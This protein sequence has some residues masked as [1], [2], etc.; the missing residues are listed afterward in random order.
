[1]LIRVS[2]RRV[3]DIL[4]WTKDSGVFRHAVLVLGAHVWDAHVHYFLIKN[5]H[6]HAMVWPWQSISSHILDLCYMLLTGWVAW[7]RACTLLDHPTT[8]VFLCG[9]QVSTL[10][11]LRIRV[12]ITC[13]VRQDKRHT[14]LLSDVQTHQATSLIIS[15]LQF[16]HPQHIISL[17]SI[18]TF[19][20]WWH[21]LKR[22]VKL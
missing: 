5:Y 7:A 20:I 18:L 17:L 22:L 3:Q 11:W 16:P 13:Q 19:G 14:V 4:F 21:R 9:R 1:M 6:Y 10:E 2:V 12:I 15:E 8:P